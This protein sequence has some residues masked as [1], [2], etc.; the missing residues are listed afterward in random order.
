[1]LDR[2]ITGGSIVDG[3]GSPRRLGDVSIRDGKIVAVGEPGTA[4]PA[5]ETIDATGL[6][7]A[8]GFVD[9]HTHYDAQ[10]LWDPTAS[11]S[12]AH[13]VTS[14]I[15]GNC[16]FT[17]APLRPNDAD[18]TRRMMARV[19]GMPLAALEAGSSWQWESFGEYLDGL[20]GRIGVNA[21]FLVGHCALRRYVM[22]DDAVQREATDDEISK[23]AALLRDSLAA[24]GLGLS[25]SRS[26]SHSDGD[27]NPVASRLASV[28]EVLAL[29]RVVGEF[30]GTTLEAI[31][32]GCTRRFQ[33]D[34]I[35]LLATMSATAD[36][37]LNWNVLIVSAHDEALAFH[38]LSPSQRAREV[39][40]RVMALT[41][42]VHAQ[43]NMSFE[44][45][46]ALWLIPGWEPIM[47]LPA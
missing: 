19:E 10:L 32:E 44:T 38:Q 13:G 43:M 39:G 21:G 17:L 35:E 42:P 16:G 6:I 14:V 36:R 30:E 26:S 37:P 22:G 11:P 15:G 8:P 2:V 18:Y 24:G 34:E 31:T 45:F 40:G 1:M 29:C 9:P 33:P 7:V 23:M 25:T 28:D 5:R 47:R 12:A 4:E 20:E 3:T 27:G 41:M 46:C